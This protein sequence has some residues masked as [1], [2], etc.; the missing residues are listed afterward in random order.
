MGSPEGFLRKFETCPGRLINLKL[1]KTNMKKIIFF[2]IFTALLAFTAFQHV[3]AIGMMTKPIVIK[4]I[5]RGQEV[6]IKLTLLNSENRE[7]MYGLKVEGQI[8]DWVSFYKAE[9]KNLQ[10]P[11]TEI[12][13]PLKNFL[14]IQMKFNIP[15][16]APNGKYTGKV[17]AYLATGEQPKNDDPS[18]NVLQQVG[19]E[20]TITV[21]D[22]EIIK[23]QAAFIPGTYSVQR[24]NP[25]TIKVLYDNQGNVATKPDLQ[26]KI[27]KDGSTVYNAIFPY[28]EDEVAVR[29][30]ANKEIPPAEWHTTGQ[31]DGNYKAELTVFLGGKEMQKESFSFSVGDFESSFLA[32]ISWLWKGSFPLVL[33]AIIPIIAVLLIVLAVFNKK[34]LNLKKAR[35]MFDN[36]IKLFND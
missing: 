6:L 34:I 9:D 20:V 12:A 23:L 27:T 24:G 31:Q 5:R 36:F 25:L 19:R 18:A 29:A 21:T 1:I 16:D 7:V 2:A 14:D 32:G 33:L 15:A 26:L 11:I 17:L 22:K 13:M 8:T 28:P 30:Y 10:N 35:A 3:F 4:D